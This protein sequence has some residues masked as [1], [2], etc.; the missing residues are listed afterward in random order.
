MHELKSWDEKKT[1]EKWM[2]SGQ[3]SGSNHRTLR[4]SCYLGSWKVG[5]IDRGTSF[6]DVLNLASLHYHAGQG[7]RGQL[8]L[9]LLLFHYMS[10][11]RFDA[12]IF[13][14]Q[15]LYAHSRTSIKQTAESS[16]SPGD[17]LLQQSSTRLDAPVHGQ[18]ISIS[19]HR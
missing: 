7:P 17:A 15:A 11:L 3:G 14:Q 13:I 18:H 1:C 8:F 10:F 16:G 12:L 6:A 5:T 9:S 19:H 4:N 2:D